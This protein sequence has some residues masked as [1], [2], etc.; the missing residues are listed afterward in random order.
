MFV[1]TEVKIPSCFH[2]MFRYVL[3]KLLK[4]NVQRARIDK[5]CSLIWAMEI[6]FS[7]SF[8]LKYISARPLIGYMNPIV[9]V[10][11]GDDLELNCEAIVGNPKPKV[12]WLRN[13]L[14]LQPDRNIRKNDNGN[15]V[16]KEVQSKHDGDYI[17][18]ATNVGGNASIIVSVD[19]QGESFLDKIENI[20]NTKF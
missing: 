19:V 2:L 17:C 12:L 8:L 18:L 6:V 1:N 11:Q 10:I 5:L 20:L 4:W 13:G 14:V 9:S 16:I 3:T 7:M 15:L